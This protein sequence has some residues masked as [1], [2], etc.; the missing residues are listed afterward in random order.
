MNEKKP[1]LKTGAGGRPLGYGI[2][3]PY[4]IQQIQQVPVWLGGKLVWFTVVMYERVL[5]KFSGLPFHLPKIS[6]L[7]FP[8]FVNNYIYTFHSSI[9]CCRLLNCLPARSHLSNAWSH[10]AGVANH[11]DIRMPAPVCADE[12]IPEYWS[13]TEI[14]IVSLTKN[15]PLDDRCSIFFALDKTTNSSLKNPACLNTWKTEFRHFYTDLRRFWK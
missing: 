8:V 15:Y 5:Y 11:Y 6:L 13:V 14:T 4:G 9:R 7:K 3:M 10:T 1:D 12:V 2:I